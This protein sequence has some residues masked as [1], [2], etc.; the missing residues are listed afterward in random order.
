MSE[1]EFTLT[2]HILI[3]ILVIHMPILASQDIMEV[4]QDTAMKDILIDIHI[5]NLQQDIEVIL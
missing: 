2:Q 3:Y 5:A 4:I 1:T